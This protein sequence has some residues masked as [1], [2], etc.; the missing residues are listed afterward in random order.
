MK[1]CTMCGD[2]KEDSEFSIEKNGKLH[3]W[4]K[5]CKTRYHTQ[6]VREYRANPGVDRNPKGKIKV[7]LPQPDVLLKLIEAQGLQK[8]ATL[9]SCHQMTILKR[10]KQAGLKHNFAGKTRVSVPKDTLYKMYFEDGKS[11]GDIVGIT[12]CTI[13]HLQSSFKKYGWQAREQTKVNISKSRSFGDQHIIDVYKKFE[14]TVAAASELNMSPQRINSI[15]HRNNVVC[16]GNLK[17]AKNGGEKVVCEW[18]GEFG[19]VPIFER[20][21][22]WDRGK[23]LS[24]WNHIDIYVPGHKLFIEFHGTNYHAHLTERD[25][26]KK[27]EFLAAYPDHKWV[28]VQDTQL[29]NRSTK[30]VTK[31]NLRHLFMPLP[32][33][34]SDLSF[35]LCNDKPYALNFLDKFHAR[36]RSSFNT[37]LF[38]LSLRGVIVGVATFGPPQDIT[39]GFE[40]EFKRL[41][42]CGGLPVNAA[43]WFIQKCVN[44]LP[45]GVRI[46]TYVD[47]EHLGSSFKGCNWTCTG[48]TNPA[49]AYHFENAAGQQLNRRAATD[50]AQKAN[51]PRSIWAM[52]NGWKR[53][54]DLP[55]Q[56]FEFV[57]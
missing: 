10:L 44:Q 26:R 5:P 31:E 47:S 53:V 15:L 57:V 19:V 7:V 35:D 28:V 30:T 13:W 36:G 25:S 49:H 52:Q 48:M 18:L 45:K 39:M 8:T 46:I 6:K 23:I 27:N 17:A 37:H 1:K 50:K 33:S 38:T 12:G 22:G 40:F 3:S 56:I 2:T 43:S 20:W 41:A 4:C 42:L 34:T 9:L 11:L 14:S 55:K 24:Q 16:T 54:N 21:D 32:L 29:M 51:L